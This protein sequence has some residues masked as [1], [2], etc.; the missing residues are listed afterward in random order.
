MHDD[1]AQNKHRNMSKD[2]F[3]TVERYISYYVTM[4]TSIVLLLLQ[5][6]Q[7]KSKYGAV[8]A[9]ISYLCLHRAFS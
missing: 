8:C 4:P 2:R 5:L 6:I 1:M 7:E 9:L 3:E